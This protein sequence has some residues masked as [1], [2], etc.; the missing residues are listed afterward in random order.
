V[1]R[2]V[3]ETGYGSTRPRDAAAEEVQLGLVTDDDELERRRAAGG[4]R[5]DEQAPVERERRAPCRRRLTASI[6]P[7]PAN[8]REAVG[9]NQRADAHVGAQV[10]VLDEELR[11]T[12]LGVGDAVEVNHLPQLALDG[13]D[14]RLDLAAALRP[15]RG[16]QRVIDELLVEE[17]LARAHVAPR[18]E[19]RAAIGVDPLAF[20]MEPN[21]RAQGRDDHLT[22]WPLGEDMPDDKAREVVLNDQQPAALT[23]DAEL[24]EIELPEGV[25]VRASKRPG[26]SS[27]TG[28][29]PRCTGAKPARL[30]TRAMAL[31]ESR[32]PRNRLSWA[33]I[34]AGPIDG[35]F[36]L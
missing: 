7:R 3:Q 23:A 10:V 14:Q 18:G 1:P 15:V 22:R 36:F 13:I 17:D 12:T 16:A 31:T 11:Q 25:A 26:C 6:S 27:P 24:G 28:R 2:A 33:R 5:L 20:S 19:R 21:R 29:P 9:R 30:S 8:G 34:C 32:Q 35:C 4:G